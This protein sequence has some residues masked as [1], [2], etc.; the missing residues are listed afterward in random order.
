M[1]IALS[2]LAG[3]SLCA[4]AILG[5]AGWHKFWTWFDDVMERNTRQRRRSHAVGHVYWDGARVK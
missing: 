4:L 2:I 5:Y 1:I 3:V